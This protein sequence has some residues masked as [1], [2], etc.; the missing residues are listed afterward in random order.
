MTGAREQLLLCLHEVRII[1][2]S[3]FL[4]YVA[5]RYKMSLREAAYR[6]YVTDIFKSVVENVFEAR[7]DK[8][9]AEIA[10]PDEFRRD[11]RP[12]EEIVQEIVDKLG[13]KV[14]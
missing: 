1:S 8:R 5:T 12:P 6:I 3:S 13:I 4:R 14:I 11:E 9:Y 10:F 7:I 2:V